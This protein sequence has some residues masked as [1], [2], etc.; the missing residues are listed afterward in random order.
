MWGEVDIDYIGFSRDKGVKAFD[1]PETSLY[2]HRELVDNHQNYN[3]K[4]DCA[5][6]DYPAA[7]KCMGIPSS[8]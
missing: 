1:A 4:P 2:L 6:H 3:M 5:V 8:F 7:D